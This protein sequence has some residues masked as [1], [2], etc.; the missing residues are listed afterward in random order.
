MEGCR[1]VVFV[2]RIADTEGEPVMSFSEYTIKEEEEE[3][4]RGGGGRISRVTAEVVLKE[5]TEW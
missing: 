5:T 1:V 4:E 3:E 2:S